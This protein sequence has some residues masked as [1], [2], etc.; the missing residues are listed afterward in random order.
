MRVAITGATGHLGHAM[1]GYLSRLNVDVFLVGHRISDLMRADVVFHLAAPDH[2]DH[3]AIAAFTSFNEDL[4]TW[5]DKHSV[6]V[7]NTA[8]WWQ[9]AGE[10]AQALDY[11]RLKAAQQQLFSDH[12][13]LTLY[14]VYGESAR[15]ARGFIPQLIGHL[16]G[17]HKVTAASIE[18]RDWIHMQDVCRAFL[19]AQ[20]APVGVFDVATYLKLSPMA[21][22]MIFTDEPMATWPDEPSAHCYYPNSRLPGWRAEI[23][24][25]QYIAEALRQEEAWQSPM[26]I[27][28]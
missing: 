27:A 19:A 7:I 26:A 3:D 5:S 28:R 20:H 23:A 1:V 24:V 12:T 8:T 21:L 13:T 17:S 11:T 9:H 18:Q 4:R 6:P 10:Q 16:T 2:R 25:T 15:S 14:S 22:A